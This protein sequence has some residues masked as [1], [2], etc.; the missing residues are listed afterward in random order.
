VKLTEIVPLVYFTLA[1]LTFEC[2]NWY[3]T[4]HV[5]QTWLQI[6]KYAILTLPFQVIGYM[7]LIRGLGLGYRAFSDV[8]QLLITTTTITWLIKL[9][10]AYGFFRK[11]P[12]LGNVVALCLLIIANIIQKVWK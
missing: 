7:L 12:T 2:I 6:A 10:T 8:W 9:V 5:Q 11:I 1:I 4:K 3:G